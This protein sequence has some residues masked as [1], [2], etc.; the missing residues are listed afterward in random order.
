MSGPQFETPFDLTVRIL[1]ACYFDIKITEE[2]T[3][4]QIYRFARISGKDIKGGFC[5]PN[6]ESYWYL[7]GRVAADHSGC[8]NKWSQCPLVVELPTTEKEAREL[9]KHLNWLGT[10][11]AYEWSTKFGYIDEPNRLPRVT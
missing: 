5:E 11:E 8:F 2:A 9:V 1:S 7:D 6:G 3:K 4:N 10:R